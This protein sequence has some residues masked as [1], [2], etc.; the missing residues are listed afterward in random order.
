M[1]PPPVALFGRCKTCGAALIIT[2]SVIQC[3]ACE[4]R[5]EPPPC[6][7]ADDENHEKLDCPV[8]GA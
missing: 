1:N 8:I 5:V 6:A 2:P 4:G 3:P 7:C